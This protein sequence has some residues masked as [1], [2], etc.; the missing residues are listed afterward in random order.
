MILMGLKLIFDV[1][2]MKIEDISNINN[3]VAHGRTPLHKLI[4]LGLLTSCSNPYFFLWW[5]ATGLPIIT[6]SISMAGALGFIFFLAG[7]ASADLLWFNFV[8]YSICEGRKVLN[9]KVFRIILL[10]SSVFLISFAVHMILS[11]IMLL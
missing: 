8:S 3:I 2:R 4:F 10:V 7:H 1:F 6:N 9:E 5:L 11:A